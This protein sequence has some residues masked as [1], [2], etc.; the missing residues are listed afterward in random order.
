MS[1]QRNPYAPPESDLEPEAPSTTQHLRSDVP[2]GFVG[3]MELIL[4]SSFRWFL[5]LM[6]FAIIY[7]VAYTGFDYLVGLANAAGPTK[8]TL[9]FAAAFASLAVAVWI[10]IAGLKRADNLQR[11]IEPGGES[12]YALGRLPWAL[13][14]GVM[15]WGI[16]LVGLAFCVLPGLFLGV[17]FFAGY[18][19]VMLGDQ[20]PLAAFRRAMQLIRGPKNARTSSVTNWFYVAGVVGTTTAIA[21]VAAVVPVLVLEGVWTGDSVLTWLEDPVANALVSSMYSG[22]FFPLWISMLYW[23]FRGL[24]ARRQAVSPVAMPTSETDQ[25]TPSEPAPFEFEPM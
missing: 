12:R 10:V 22:L 24:I 7:A 18:G 9:L 13:L 16:T 23:L 1:D 19:P 14:F 3:T 6:V 4:S 11:E 25:S 8:A 21:L 5:P 17:L 2:T 20:G 15:Y